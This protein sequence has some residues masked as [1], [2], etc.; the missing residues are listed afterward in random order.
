M[1]ILA[2]D[3]PLV[4]GTV[5]PYGVVRG[6]EQHADG[7]ALDVEDP[8]RGHAVLQVAC[9]PAPGA[10]ATLRDARLRPLALRLDVD[11]ERRCA[12]SALFASDHGPR[13]RPVPLGVALALCADGVHTVVTSR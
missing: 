6:L 7:C 10:A 11:D 5:A 1:T 3:R 12:C 4:T 2:T 8:A 13:R 9:A